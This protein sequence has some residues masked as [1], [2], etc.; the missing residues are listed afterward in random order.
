MLR[1]SK[2]S[3]VLGDEGLDTALDGIE[4]VFLMMMKNTE[5]KRCYGWACEESDGKKEKEEVSWG[6]Q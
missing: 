2:G 1:I 4:K 5:R 6:A 3:K